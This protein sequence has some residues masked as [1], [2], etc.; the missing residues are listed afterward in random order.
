MAKKILYLMHVD[1][2]W[3]KQRPHFI[4]EGLS[5]F[6]DV[7]VVCLNPITKQSI[8]SKQS[9]RRNG[10]EI[11]KLVPVPFC[12]KKWVY[13]LN[14]IYLKLIFQFIIKKYKPDYIWVPFP[15][16]YD[17]LPVK[18]NFKII[19]D[20]MDDAVEFNFSDHYKNKILKLEKELIKN[21]SII[22]VSS[23]NLASKLKK[24]QK[25][26][27]KLFLI[28]NAFD[29]NILEVSSTSENEEKCENYKIGYVGTV[30][31]W[32]DFETLGYLL[33]KFENIEF[34]I[35][36]PHN[37][38]NSH[39]LKNE[40]IKF[41]GS[42]EHEKLNFYTKEFDCMMMPFKLNELV[43]SVDPVKFY[44]YI[45]YNKPIISI[46]Y[47]ELRRY[48]PYVDFYSNITELVDLIDKMIKN[49][50]QN[51]YSTEQ[52]INFLK[53]NSWDKRVS[54]I[55]EHLTQMRD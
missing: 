2:D 6:Y 26:E 17:Y 15:T 10:L 30:S 43:R 25:C 28:R 18:R 35:I 31:S 46:F 21:S 12:H 53:S 32:V 49:G 50:F 54:K 51:K 16:L 38:H 11:H 3:I 45:N 42:I 44:E 24:R 8:H 22:F 13:P 1:W 5:Q 9:T 29:G 27:D 14:K 39:L 34:H 23:D 55:V 19:Y 48:F 52:R 4:A 40:R 47:D 20:C 7:E 41:Y 37:L 33:K 36:G